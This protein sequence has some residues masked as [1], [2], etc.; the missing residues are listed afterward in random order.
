[1]SEPFSI[2]KHGITV[3]EVLRNPAP[4]RLYEL[5]L[6]REH[7]TAITSTGALVALSGSKTG[8]SPKDKRIVEEPGSTDDIWWGPVNIKMSD[9]IFL[10]NRERCIDYLN[11]REILYCID[12]FAGWDPKYRIKVRVICERAYHALF[13]WNML[14]RPTEKELEAFGD[15]DYVI[16]N[17]G[18]FPANR[19]TSGMTS[20]TTIDL[21]FEHK[22]L[23]ILGTEYAGEMKKG[24]FT[25][26]NYLMPK[27][28]VLSMHC[29]A[30]EGKNGDVSVLFGLSGTGKTTLS[31]DPKRQLIG[32]D[33]HAWTDEGVFN[34]EGGCYAK[35]INLTEEA[36]PDIFRAIRF[37]SVLENVVYDGESRVVDYANVTI[38]DNTRCSY[39]I[40]YI[41]GAKIPCVA[42]H[43]NNVIF[44]TAD[45]FGVLP[46]VAKL[47]AEQAMYHFISGY[48][49]KVAGTEVGVTEPQATFSACFGQPFMVWHPT[50]YAELLAARLTKHDAPVWLVNTGWTGGPYGVGSR[51][52]L[53]YTRA[54]IDAI[55][56]GELAK[57]LTQ[58]DPVFGLAI[59]TW[60]PNVPTELLVPRNTW[61]DKAAYDAT[62]KKLSGLF[63]DNF[64]KYAQQ[65]SERVRKAGPLST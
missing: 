13:M 42:G 20:T 50:K 47:S 57:V 14:I 8:R 15:P 32:D 10:T 46:P 64:K 11:T 31:A 12:G 27:K 9:H 19:Y 6:Q 48:T 35:A 52:K 55:H 23:V 59:P 24:V 53:K 38:T 33:E 51:M 40:E 41:P 7:G 21:S 29:S 4:A 17:G 2:A 25:I 30:T 65:A 18:P 3:Q 26:M 36:E 37:G 45:A 60:C 43:P 61:A 58:V 5:A 39:P 16:F 44:L 28:G 1:M 63:A 34:V 49:A 56:S 54:I 62:A 22:E